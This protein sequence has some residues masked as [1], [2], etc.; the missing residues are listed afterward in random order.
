VPRGRPAESQVLLFDVAGWARAEADARRP[1][2]TIRQKGRQV[3][4][5]Y[6]ASVVEVGGRNASAALDLLPRT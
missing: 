5:P 1:V 6:A 4:P 3:G 2:A